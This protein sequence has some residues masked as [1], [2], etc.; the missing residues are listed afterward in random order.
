MIGL[1]AV[2]LI[3]GFASRAITSVMDMGW[4]AA[5]FATFD[6]SAIVW[7][8][9]VL[10]LN[11]MWSAP[12]EPLLPLDGVAAGVCLLAFLLPLGQTSWLALTLLSA[13]LGI[14]SAPR[15]TL[16]RAALLLFAIG[17]PM[18]WA[19]LL[20]SFFSGP[21]LNADAAMVAALV[22]TQAV[23]N[24]VPFPDGSGSLWIAPACS[25]AINLALALLC[26]TTFVV[27][28]GL[29][30][31]WRMAGWTLLACL[32]VV[33]VNIAR[34]AAL[35]LYPSYYEALHGPEGGAAFSLLI[36]AVMVGIFAYA[37]RRERTPAL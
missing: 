2:G 14:T 25:S 20:I 32:S 34:L 29:D 35:A 3:N 13:Y 19:R 27:G 22:G 4:H 15:S 8:S 17:L 18:M 6:V 30:W 37:A 1:T 5:V 36:L 31:S 23:E 12:R 28:Y 26:G 16:R 21:L 10:L 9:C 24:T 7:I 11:L 33:A